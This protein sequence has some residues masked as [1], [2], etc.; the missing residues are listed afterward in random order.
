V[1]FSGA[2][3]DSFSVVLVCKE[4]VMNLPGI[5]FTRLA[6]TPRAGL[7]DTDSHAQVIRSAG[8]LL[9]W[10]IATDI[11]ALLIGF[12]VALLLAELV[13]TIFFDRHLWQ[14]QQDQ[15][16]LKLLQPLFIA[17]GVLLWFQYHDHYRVRLPFW[18]QSK[19]V[20]EAFGFAMLVEGFLQ[21]AEKQDASRLWLVSSWIIAAFAVI[22]L[23]SVIRAYLY[24]RGLFQ[25]RTLLVGSGE[26]AKRVHDAL[27]SDP[28][29]GYEVTARIKNL[30]AAFLHAGASWKKLCDQYRAAYV[31]L[32]LEGSEWGAE[33]PL[34]QL[35]REKVSFSLSPPVSHLPVAGIMQHYFLNHDVIL[36]TC[37]PTLEQAFPCGMKRMFDTLLS[38]AALLVL[39]PVM[40]AVALL[41]R[42]DGGPA[43]YGHPRLGRNGGTFSCFKF[44]TMVADG[45]A[46]LKKHLQE[47]PAAYEEWRATRKLQQ[48]PRITPFGNFLRRSSLDELPQLFNVL[49]GDMS[50]VGPRPI[51]NA[52]VDRYEGDIAHYYRVRPGITGLWQV[53]GRND[54]SYAQRVHMDSWYVRN[55]SLWH[56]I[57]ILC[58]TIPALI[59]RQGAY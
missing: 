6:A 42:R 38:S 28:S 43:L 1:F 5:S 57:A 44:R 16:A 45:D 47:N 18:L 12:S 19:Q 31:I 3:P 49:L 37:S 27:K 26:T 29:L 53:S 4:Y 36:M 7:D 52:E 14:P 13:N 59:N 56:D 10:Y 58:K 55:W 23:R 54:V 21:F 22:A 2:F 39:S 17:I 46:V 35:T 20:A 11:L 15:E 32:A 48:D 24:K 8:R 34:A 41:I 51:V 50:L 40:I 25:V 30:P 33:K 9:K